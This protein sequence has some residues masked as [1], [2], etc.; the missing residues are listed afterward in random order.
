[1]SYSSSIVATSYCTTV[2]IVN[3][4]RTGRELKHLTVNRADFSHYHLPFCELSL[5]FITTAA[6]SEVIQME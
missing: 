3:K 5:P 1:M 2:V 4:D 6:L